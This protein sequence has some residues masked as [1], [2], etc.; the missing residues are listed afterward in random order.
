MPQMQFTL[1][2]HALL[3]ARG[4]AHGFFLAFSG[5]EMPR[6]CNC[7]ADLHASFQVLRYGQ[8][9][10]KHPSVQLEEL[11]LSYHACRS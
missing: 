5:G 7:E 9:Q 1:T 2:A 8:G 6:L 11:K 4:M 10:Q 3:C